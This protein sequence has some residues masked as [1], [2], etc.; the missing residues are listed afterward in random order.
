LIERAKQFFRENISRRN[1]E[2]QSSD[3]MVENLRNLFGTTKVDLEKLQREAGNLPEDD[4][5]TWMDVTMEDLDSMLQK[6]F[7][8]S[9]A[10]SSSSANPQDIPSKLKEFMSKVAEVEGV[11]LPTTSRS[12]STPG[13]SEV[14]TSPCGAMDPMDF[15]ADDFVS[16]MDKLLTDLGK[17]DEDWDESD[18]DSYSDEEGMKEIYSE[19][20]FKQNSKLH[21]LMNQ[22]DKELS[23]TDVGKTFQA[24][25]ATQDSEEFDDVESF[26]PVDIDINAL[27]NML[28]S[29]QSQE[30]PTGPSANLLRSVCYDISKASGEPHTKGQPK[31][32][33]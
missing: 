2:D 26:E 5:D 15:R 18:D 14:S 3:T 21:E 31:R 28:K 6:K 4:D 12:R 9:Q 22:M 29:F 8:F 17:P 25:D 20:G 16:A 7:K 33:K 19:H 10:D 27:Q 23:T 1:G 30:T 24:P 13:T 32:K 11:D